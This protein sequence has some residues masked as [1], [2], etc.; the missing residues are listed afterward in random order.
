MSNES[1]AVMVTSSSSESLDILSRL[2]KAA[3]TLDMEVHIYFTG[4]AVKYL[5]KDQ[6]NSLSS[7]KEAKAAG[8]VSIYA[9]SEALSSHNLSKNEL[10]DAVDMTSGY[11][12]FLTL[13]TDATVSLTV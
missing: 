5:S 12:Y 8:S 4:D 10:S 1:I 11:V 2:A 7:L 13:A 6:E 3:V 9:C